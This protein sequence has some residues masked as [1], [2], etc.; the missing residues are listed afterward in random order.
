MSVA[1]FPAL[2][3]HQSSVSELQAAVD[4]LAEECERLEKLKHAAEAPE[5]EAKERFDKQWEGVCGGGL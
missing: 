4:T 2:Q 5:K 1:P 3:T